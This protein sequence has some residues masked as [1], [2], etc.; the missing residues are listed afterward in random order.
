MR[1][2]S[3]IADVI[4]IGLQSHVWHKIN[5][6]CIYKLDALPVTSK[7]SGYRRNNTDNTQQRI[8]V[9]DKNINS[10]LP[11][12]PVGEDTVFRCL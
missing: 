8:S 2:D 11:E 4:T 7:L 5:T 3:S 9:R 12:C 6:A 1:D 10:L